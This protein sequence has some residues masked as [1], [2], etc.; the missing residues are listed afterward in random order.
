M[1]APDPPIE[2]RL[3]RIA[4]LAA[5]YRDDYEAFGYYIET[6]WDREDRPAAELDALVDAIAADVI[7]QIDC[8][9]CANCC[10]G[11]TVGLTPDDIPPLAEGL[12][13]PPEH[14]IARYVDRQG[15]QPHDE[16]GIFRGTPCPLLRGKLCSVYA[17]RPASCRDYPALTP[18]F[19]WQRANIFTGV[20]HCPI[21]FN[22]IERLKQRL[23][24]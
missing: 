23:A 6:M 5:E 10:R 21:I 4:A 16:W 2:T 20:G 15:A 1:T 24:W 14:V 11:L 19:L 9:A 18:D 7:P 17:H 3:E 12:N 22:V 8:T 13:L